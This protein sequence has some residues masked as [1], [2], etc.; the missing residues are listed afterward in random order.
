[1]STTDDT[2][3]TTTFLNESKKSF[4][5]STSANVAALLFIKL[6]T[7][8][9]QKTD[10][11]KLGIVDGKGKVLKRIRDMT[12]DEKRSY[13]LFHRLVFNI[14]R[15][16]GKIPFA[17]RLPLLT[18]FF[19]A[20]MLLKENTEDSKEI[21]MKMLLSEEK[22]RMSEILNEDETK[23]L[24]S[25]IYNNDDLFDSIPLMFFLD[26]TKE[27]KASRDLVNTETFEP[28]I[29]EGSSL[30]ILQRMKH[31][32]VPVY[33]AVNEESGETTLIGSGDVKDVVVEMFNNTTS[34]VGNA[35]ASIPMA[36]YKNKPF[37]VFDVDDNT[38][39][40]FLTPRKKYSRWSSYFPPEEDDETDDHLPNKIKKCVQRGHQ[41]FLRDTKGRALTIQNYRGK[42]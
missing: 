39:S 28:T 25:F 1:M 20:F 4:L 41:V 13:T 27:Y 19:T 17:N 12:T 11:Y 32:N 7:T 18:S 37:S 34:S 15:L 26:E 10:A 30:R 22:L 5:V 14:K 40:R 16:L 36:V 21:T 8:P 2:T 23:M 3:T 9:W 31:T 33:L 29:S 24:S 38:F 42:R 35:G 6:L